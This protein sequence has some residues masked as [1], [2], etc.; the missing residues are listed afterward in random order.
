MRSS[1]L[2]HVRH[3]GASLLCVLTF[4]CSNPA[5][6]PEEDGG[7]DATDDG[8]VL[9]DGGPD[10]ADGAPEGGEPDGDVPD[11]GAPD[12]D[13]PDEP[14]LVA[15]VESHDFGVLAPSAEA[16]VTLTFRND[17]G[18]DTGALSVVLDGDAGFALTSNGCDG[19]VLA[20]GGACEIAVR[21]VSSD[22]G[23]HAAALTVSGTPGGSA[24]VA[25]DATVTSQAE[26]VLDDSA[27]DFG[28]LPVGT[29]ASKVL[30]VSNVGGLTSAVIDTSLAGASAFS[31]EDDDCD[32]VTL[33][34]AATCTITLQYAPTSAG[35]HTATL[36]VAADGAT[37]TH[38]AS[39][40]AIVATGL[41]ITPS[42]LVFPPTASGA[43]SEPFELTV[44][45]LGDE[46]TDA[47]LTALTGSDGSEFALEED[48][49]AGVALAPDASCTMTLRFAPTGG[50][51][52]RAASVFIAGAPVGNAIAS[53]VGE[54]R[55][56]SLH[57][58]WS[59]FFGVVDVGTTSHTTTY[60]VVNYGN[61]PTGPITVEVTGDDAAQLTI[62]ENECDT[63][64]APQ[65]LCVVGLRLRPTRFGPISATLKI[66]ATPGGTVSFP[67]SGTGRDYLPLTVTQPFTGAGM[68]RVTGGGLDCPNVGC[69][70]QVPRTTGHPSVTLTAI[71]SLSSS[72]VGWSEAC[73]AAGAATT[74]TIT[75]EG[76]TTVGAGFARVMHTLTVTPIS[77]GAA[78]GTIRS[79]TLHPLPQQLECGDTCT[80]SV[81]HGTNV[82]LTSTPDAGAYPGG[83]SGGCTSDWLSCGLQVT[84]DVNV[85]VTFTPANLAFTTPAAYTTAEIKAH[86]TDDATP[87][88]RMISGADALCQTVGG[89]PSFRAFIGGGDQ[90]AIGRLPRNARGF[91]R[92]DGL[93]FTTY[94]DPASAWILHPPVLD[95]DGERVPTTT[96]PF[97]WTGVD[98]LGDPVNGR[99]CGDWTDTGLVSL[100]ILGATGYAWSSEGTSACNAT[101]RH[102]L[103]CLDT[104]YAAE[105]F[106]PEPPEDGRYA[107]VTWGNFDPST[108]LEGADALCNE[109]ARFFLPGTYRAM[110]ATNGTTIAS[111]FTHRDEPIYRADGAMIAESSEALLSGE[112]PLTSIQLDPT[113]T[114]IEG[115]VFTGATS[116]VAPGTTAS[117]CYSAAGGSWSTTAVLGG[118]GMSNR[119]YEWVHSAS[120][121]CSWPA[122]VYCLRE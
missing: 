72:F 53:I 46:T 49:C 31:L 115:V 116:T 8:D 106:P 122:H 80:I 13:V 40:S 20:A 60:S 6:E 70:A 47:L 94:L 63:P 35:D 110:L 103:L 41:V 32:G 89:A 79:T 44:T 61:A 48:A 100:G 117:T 102:H 37:L 30:R 119:L 113:T 99:T 104:R 71:P 21:F 96:S 45:N 88:T 16:S 75:L 97:V 27:H 12:G 38:S 29:S 69:T 10:G 85:N 14:R 98:V 59:T 95:A 109:E 56:P 26:L 111:R 78:T 33:A 120:Y 43:Q 42:G 28:V 73:A 19:V 92:A 82:W 1:P 81:P 39:G 18:G 118:A 101:T 76:A 9:A 11:G 83:F 68:G 93:P 17:G 114:P 121:A 66:T 4:A 84:A 52:M 105:V 62:V 112:V 23:V 50:P 107:F 108:G 64:L 86:A 58:G 34:P 5:I 57:S 3:F 51:G 22:G 77:I 65:G 15:A 91:V 7:T 55:A 90:N 25:L 67:L 74:C 24:D 87:V 36:E 54:A 2:A